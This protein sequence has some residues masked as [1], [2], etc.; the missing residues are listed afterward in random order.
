VPVVVVAL[1]VAFAVVLAVAFAVV[2]ALVVAFPVVLTLAVV[3]VAFTIVVALALT[4]ALAL[5]VPAAAAVLVGGGNGAYAALAMGL[6]LL[7]GGLVRL[8]GLVG[9]RAVA[10]DGQDG[11]H[12]EKEGRRGEH[13]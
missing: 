2:L 3:M 5:V 9:A 8:R 1:A 6:F 7:D 12:G 10:A 4:S 11:R 13:A